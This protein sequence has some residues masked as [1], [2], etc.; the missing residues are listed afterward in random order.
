MGWHSEDTV[1]WPKDPDVETTVPAATPDVQP[2]PE[3]GFRM[4]YMRNGSPGSHESQRS[5]DG[6]IWNGHQRTLHEAERTT[7]PTADFDSDGNIWLYYNQQNEACA[8]ALHLD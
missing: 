6:F 2:D 5:E 8:K 4:F 7:N 1:T 3:G